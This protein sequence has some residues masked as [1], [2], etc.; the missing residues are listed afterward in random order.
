MLESLSGVHFLV[1]SG[2]LSLSQRI[3]ESQNAG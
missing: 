1:P 3:I 2:K